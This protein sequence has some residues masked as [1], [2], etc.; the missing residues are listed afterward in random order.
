M[1]KQP[2]SKAFMD[3]VNKVSAHRHVDQFTEGKERHLSDLSQSRCRGRCP[4]VLERRPKTESGILRLG[5]IRPHWTVRVTRSSDREGRSK[6]E[7]RVV[8]QCRWTLSLP[9]ITTG[10]RRLRRPRS[11]KRYL[12]RG[13]SF[14]YLLVLV[15]KVSDPD[16]HGLFPNLSSF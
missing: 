7:N 16:S 3:A 5:F 11:Q 10:P 9:Y 12:K 15:Y 14:F 8:P 1:R 2:L 6:T 13:P 4:L